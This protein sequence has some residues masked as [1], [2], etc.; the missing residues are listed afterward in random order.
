[1]K[2]TIRKKGTTGILAAV[3]AVS[4]VAF[5]A[6]TPGGQQ[7]TPAPEN[8]TL[9]Q[10]MTQPVELT[11]Q[12][13]PTIPT[14]TVDPETGVRA[15]EVEA[16]SFYYQPNVIRVKKGETIK[17]TLNSVDMMHDF[18]IDELDV[19]IPVTAGGQSATVEFT[20]D[21][22]GTFEFY[23]SVGEHRANGQVGTLIVE[24]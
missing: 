20:A 9:E 24:E 23:C 18:N 22:V 16:G 5:A 10:G 15:I 19:S 4:A 8:T 17:L 13:D 6:C 3:V 12:I 1:M 14:G 21:T 2:Q 7:Q 11:P